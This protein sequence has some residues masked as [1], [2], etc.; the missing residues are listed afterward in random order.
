[1]ILLPFP[2]CSSTAFEPLSRIKFSPLKCLVWFLSSHLELTKVDPQSPNFTC[3]LSLNVTSSFHHQGLGYVSRMLWHKLFSVVVIG[4][5]RVLKMS[6]TV[7]EVSESLSF[8]FYFS[9]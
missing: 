6:L 9:T 3:T 7:T 5:L 4:E 1:M 2:S 8:A